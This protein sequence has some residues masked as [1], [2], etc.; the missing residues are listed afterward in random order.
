MIPTEL[1]IGSPIASAVLV[2]A[3]IVYNIVGRRSNNKCN[4]GGGIN[5]KEFT[6]FMKECAKRHAH[7]DKEEGASTERFKAI[8]EDISE[9]KDDIGNI[10]KEI[11]RKNHG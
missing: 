9:I 6:D 10:F 8:Q 11:S 2:L 7:L 5:R 4:N 3:L 1:L